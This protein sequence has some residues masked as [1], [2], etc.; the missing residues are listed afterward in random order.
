[1]SKAVTLFNKAIAAKIL[2]MRRAINTL[3]IVADISPDGITCMSTSGLQI[4]HQALTGIVTD[5]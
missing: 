3:M 4:G 2:W 1:M 5:N